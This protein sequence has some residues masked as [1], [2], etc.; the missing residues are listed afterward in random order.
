MASIMINFKEACEILGIDTSN[1][2]A[3]EFKKKLPK[4]EN[5]FS[6]VKIYKRSDVVRIIDG[7]KPLDYLC[8]HSTTA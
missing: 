6:K 7:F 1:P 8:N 3:N 4:Y 5:P 2:K